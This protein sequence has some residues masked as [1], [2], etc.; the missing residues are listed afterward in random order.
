M[1]STPQHTLAVF[2]GKPFSG[3]SILASK[4]AELHPGRII[5][6]SKDVVAESLGLQ[7]A[8][9]VQYT[10]EVRHTLYT[11][12]QSRV[13]E[14]LQGDAPIIIAEAPFSRQTDVV[15]FIEPFRTRVSDILVMTFEPSPELRDFFVSYGRC[16]PDGTSR[17][18]I[19]FEQHDAS[20]GDFDTTLEIPGVQS[21]LIDMTFPF[22]DEQHIQRVT[23]HLGLT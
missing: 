21:T 10:A 3:K 16:H 15:N 12:F 11:A 4:L 13:G 20:S 18:L 9:G 5:A 2:R 17:D 22:S 23:R 14:A 1:N 6:V 19:G 7:R 8:K